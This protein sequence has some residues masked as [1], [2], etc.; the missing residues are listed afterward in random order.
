LPIVLF[1][2]KGLSYEQAAQQIRCP[3]R[4]VQSRLARGRERLRARLARRGVSPTATLIAAFLAPDTASAAV[5]DTWKRSTVKAAVCYAAGKTSASVPPTVAALARGAL[6]A[7]MLD[8][9]KSAAA[10]A[11]LLG[12]IAGGLGAWARS[13]PPAPNDP[14]RPYRLTM[15]N[16]TKIEV[17]GVSAHPSA[18]GRWWRPDGSPLDEELADRS[19]EDVDAPDSRGRA[20]LIRVADLPEG[21]TF[22][23]SPTHDGRSWG[24]EPKKDGRRLR[25]MEMYV[26]SY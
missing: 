10:A 14:E 13:E 21:A 15:V 11:L 12:V 16:G 17:V 2:F 4:T 3:V 20:I 1:H 7:M 8:K 19:S 26:S 18:P 5:M 22:K 6:K 23:W 25:G 9:L 24:I